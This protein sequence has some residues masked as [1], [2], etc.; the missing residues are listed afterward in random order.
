MRKSF[1][2]LDDALLERLFQPASDVMTHRLGLAR[3]ATAC[4]CVDVAI[5]AWIVSCEPRLS[6]AVMAWNAGG[7]FVDLILLLAG[8]AAMVSLRELLRR[9]DSDKANPLRPAMQPHRAIVLLM[10]VARLAQ[11]QSP[12]L[13][14]AADLVMLVSAVAALYLGACAERPPIRRVLA[15]LLPVR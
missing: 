6:A 5:V 1:A 3:S 9:R 2:T 7:A 11:W 4:A 8:L 13:A 12:G 15:S 14:E 10:L